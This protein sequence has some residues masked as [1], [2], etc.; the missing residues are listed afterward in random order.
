MKKFSI[1]NRYG[2]NIIGSILIPEN[3]IGLAFVLHGLGGV[4]SSR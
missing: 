2:L 3:S 4:P 1:N